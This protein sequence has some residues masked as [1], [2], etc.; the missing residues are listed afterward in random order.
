[1]LNALVV[2]WSGYRDVQATLAVHKLSQPLDPSSP[3]PS[4]PA[5]ADSKEQRPQEEEDED[6]CIDLVQV[7]AGYML[8]VSSIVPTYN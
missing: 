2:R 1:M 3:P 7:R 6:L 4:A 5:P 8:K